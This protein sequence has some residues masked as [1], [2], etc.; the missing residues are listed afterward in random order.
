MKLNGHI[1][2]PP[3]YPVLQQFAV[4]SMYTRASKVE[5]NNKVLTSS[6]DTKGRLRIVL[7]TTA[8]GMGVDCADV[9]VIYFWGHQQVL[10]STCKN[11][12]E[13]VE[14]VC[15]QKPYCYIANLANT[16]KKMLR[17]MGKILQNVIEICC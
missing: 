11:Q 9:R 5:M 4:L 1:T 16:S 15:H 3:N 17:N 14:M 6:C 8:F 2:F 12:G 13:L 10:K 7:A